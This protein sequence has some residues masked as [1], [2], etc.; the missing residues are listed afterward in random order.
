MWQ[1]NRNERVRLRGAKTK[2]SGADLSLLRSTDPWEILL[3]TLGDLFQI[4][5]TVDEFDDR[6][7]TYLH[8][9]TFRGKMAGHTLQKAKTDSS[10]D[11]MVEGSGFLQW[12]SVYALALSPDVDVVLL[13]EPDAHLH[14]SLQIQR[15]RLDPDSY[16]APT[17]SRFGFANSTGIGG[18]AGAGSPMRAA[19]MARA[20]KS[21]ALAQRKRQVSMTL[22]SSATLCEPTGVRVP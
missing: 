3:R 5:L 18:S 21:V 13:D 14:C 20:S 1:H 9:E 17:T 11:L 7:H 19:W 6:Y 8:V 10:R 16:H 15:N 4:G 12:L 2:I 22:A